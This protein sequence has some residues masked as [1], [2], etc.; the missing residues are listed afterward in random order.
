MP[1]PPAEDLVTLARKIGPEA[2][3]EYAPAI[4]ALADMQT[5]ANYLG[6][7]YGTIR[8]D[9]QRGRWPE[10]EP[11]PGRSP[12]WTYRKVIVYRAAMPGSGN[13]EPRKVA[14]E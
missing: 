13:R 2:L 9:R 5:L 8:V 4:D 1:L 12:M 14:A 6:I 3:D 7:T 11:L 10:P